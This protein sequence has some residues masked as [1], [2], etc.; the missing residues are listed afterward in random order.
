[1]ELNVTSFSFKIP[2]WFSRQVWPT[3]RS[4][5]PAARGVWA[6]SCWRAGPCW[7][8]PPRC[9]GLEASTRYCLGHLIPPCP[10]APLS[11]PCGFVRKMPPEPHVGAK[12]DEQ[13]VLIHSTVTWN[14]RCWGRPVWYNLKAFY[15]KEI[16]LSVLS[17]HVKFPWLAHPKMVSLLF[18]AVSS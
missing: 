13:S 11:C 12:G 15:R 4:W 5:F 16:I 14:I 18:N 17:L 9:M 2:R 8:W 7:P 1:M 3:L 6:A 10:A